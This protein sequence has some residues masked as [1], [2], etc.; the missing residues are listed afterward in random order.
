MPKVIQSGNS[1]A[2]TVPKKFAKMMGTKKGDKVKV[3]AVPHKGQ[4]I[5][6]FE[7]PKQLNLI[8]KK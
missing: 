3:M 6:S 2:L 1:L 8:D 7:G 4:L 5:I